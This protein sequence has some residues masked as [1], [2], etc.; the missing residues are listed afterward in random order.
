VPGG[1]ANGGVPS[2]PAVPA[3]GGDAGPTAGGLT[4]RVRGAQLPSTQ[5]L[6][7]RR[8]PEHPQDPSGGYRL[9]ERNDAHGHELGNGQTDGHTNGQANGRRGASAPPGAGGH[10]S[11]AAN[12]VYGFLTSFTQGVQRGLEETRGDPNG[13]EENP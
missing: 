9:G 4:R 12:S 5:P 11:S 1:G 3:D 10:D 13:T 6:N 8:R 7:L 2:A